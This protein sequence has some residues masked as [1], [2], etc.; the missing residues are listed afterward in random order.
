MRK[1]GLIGYPL[2]HSLSADYF[3]DKFRN[4]GVTDS[5]YLKYPIKCIDEL[6]KL[7]FDDNDICGLNVTI[8]HKSEV[9]KY[10]DSVDPAAVEIG[11]V[12]VLKI[13]RNNGRLF[14]QGFNSDIAGILGSLSP[15]PKEQL[16]NAL[17]LGTGGASKAVAYALKKLGI[18]FNVVSRK[19]EYG[20][21]E[22]GDIDGT[23]LG[24]TRLI[25]NTTPLGMFPNVDSRPEIDYS[26]L[27]NRHTLF[28]VVYNPEKTL[29]LKIGEERG[30]RIITGMKMFKLQAERSWSIWNEA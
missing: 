28:D 25:V 10:V 3:T 16:Q 22:Y 6:P 24:Q 15:I 23:V 7:L 29:F 9:M 14:I 17:I 4:E 12:N 21:L 18:N 27:D 20:I 2:G 13:A 11:A 1:F 30:C 8:P 26:Q 5:V 19:R